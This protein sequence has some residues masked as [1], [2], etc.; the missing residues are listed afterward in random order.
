MTLPRTTW[1]RPTE[2][3]KGQDHLGVQAVSGHIAA[4]LIPGLTSQTQRIGHYSFYPWLLWAYEREVG[5]KRPEML[6]EFI[7]RAEC[8][9]ALAASLHFLD[10]GDEEN[11]VA[12][13]TGRQTL[14][15][16]AKGVASG[17]KAKL[18]DFAALAG[19]G[20]S[21]FKDKLG[22][23]GQ[24]Y[25]SS[26]RQ[27]GILGGDTQEELRYTNER[28]EILAETLDKAVDRKDFF[29]LLKKDHVDSKS[30]SSLG[31]FCPC[32]LE[33]NAA[34][35]EALRDFLLNRSGT[36]FH[37]PAGVPRAESIALLLDVAG[38]PYEDDSSAPSSSLGSRFLDAAYAGVLPGGGAWALGPSLEAARLR[39]AACQ[40]HELL[41][42]S[43][44]ALFWAGLSELQEAGGRVPS[45][46][47]YGKWFSGHFSRCLPVK[48]KAPFGELVSQ[49][50]VKLPSIEAASAK[51]HELRA[52][53]RLIE[54]FRQGDRNAAVREAVKVIG[55]LIARDAGAE[56]YA[57]LPFQRGYFGG[58]EINL[59]ALSLRGRGAW[60]SLS[61]VEWL[62][63]MATNWGV[64]VHIR[65][66]LRKLHR[67]SLETFRIIPHEDG[68]EVVEPPDTRWTFPRLNQLI[69]ALVDL[70][71]VDREHHLI[72][73]GRLV[74]EELHGNG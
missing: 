67:E 64:L 10:D 53:D 14:D 56:P 19:H 31:V 54:A 15:P 59:R 49:L 73:A 45:A 51:G 7:R 63:W 28:G 74:R 29:R 61:A 30:L 26:L 71:L 32:R 58:Y 55:A 6:V 34:E 12:G 46:D 20:N 21:Y 72:E 52:A 33:S 13:L 62:H 43:V 70:G 47:A 68:L 38:S 39:W 22:G 11:H 42:V 9:L 2:R 17:K 48:P 8:A 40:R 1:V 41:S 66:A 37:D 5:D 3:R 23:L 50:A 36:P 24:Y 44:Q 16:I 25:L 60:R 65:I 18:S 27:V 35:R 4:Q 57:D 69:R